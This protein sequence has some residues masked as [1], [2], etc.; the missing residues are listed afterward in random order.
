MDK[1]SIIASDIH[2]QHKGVTMLICLVLKTTWEADPAFCTGTSTAVGTA[3]AVA[4][5]GVVVATVVAVG[6]PVPARPAARPDQ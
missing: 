3:A 4:A 2:F 6:R 5:A 1:I